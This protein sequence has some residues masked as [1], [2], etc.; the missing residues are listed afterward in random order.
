MVPAIFKM[1]PAV[2]LVSLWLSAGGV[3]AYIP[4]TP[5]NDTTAIQTGSNTSNTSNLLLQWYADG[6][7]QTHVSYQ[8]VG[9][10]SSGVAEGALVHFSEDMVINETSYT[11]WIA[12]VSCDSNT[13][14]SSNDTDIFTY[15]QSSGAVAALLY[16][17]YSQACLINPAYADPATFNQIMDIFTTEALNTASLIEYQFGQ[18]GLKNESI[19]G[20]FNAS[21]LNESVAIVNETFKTGHPQKPGYIFATLT[22]YNA[23]LPDGDGDDDGD[24]NSSATS[25]NS[26]SAKGTSV[27][28]IILY[29]ITGCVSALFCGVIVMGAIRA[30]RHPDRYGPR[31]GRNRDGDSFIGQ[32]QSRA[33]GLTRA[34]LD[35]FPIVKFGGAA[36]LTDSPVI[37]PKD[38]DIESRPQSYGPG[39]LNEWEVMDVPLQMIQHGDAK[40]DH[41]QGVPDDAEEADVT[42]MQAGSP[43]R[44]RASSSRLSGASHPSRPQSGAPAV[45]RPQIQTASGGPM[46]SVIPEAIGTETCPIC[47]VDFEEGDDLRLLPCEGKHRFHQECVDPWLLELSSSCP[48]C[49]QDFQALETMLSGESEDSHSPHPDYPPSTPHGT[50]QPLGRFSRY[51]RFARRRRNQIE[52]SHGH[53]PHGRAEAESPEPTSP[54]N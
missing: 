52:S 44:P 22:A 33:R 24:G 50:P 9:A 6:S 51:L 46:E 31:S 13:T 12:L 35:T 5:T 10:D 37:V 48:I 40:T 7:L 2:F 23:T 8:L 29:A 36:E 32:G 27:A 43:A 1:L 11:P 17:S 45:P 20:N 53:G 41:Q 38:I 42:E 30:V 28:M 47:I 21:K 26:G 16:S 34:I 4:A 39:E 15:A 49:R 19:Y 3:R 54:D 18:F 14:N 25:N